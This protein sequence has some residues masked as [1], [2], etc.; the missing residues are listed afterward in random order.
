MKTLWLANFD[1]SVT[2]YMGSTRF[3]EGQRIVWAET[4]DE[5]KQVVEA[6]YEDFSP[7]GTSR[8]VVDIELSPVLGVPD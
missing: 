6:A 8:H 1:L 4:S 3:E 2:P 7:G 5:A